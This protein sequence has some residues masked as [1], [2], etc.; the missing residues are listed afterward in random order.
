[1]FVAFALAHNIKMKSRALPTI[2]GLLI[3]FKVLAVDEPQK[4]IATRTTFLDFIQPFSTPPDTNSKSTSLQ[5]SNYTGTAFAGT[6]TDSWNGAWIDYNNDG[7][8]DLFIGSKNGTDDNLL[9][10]NNGNGSFTKITTGTLVNFKARTASSTWADINNDGRIDVFIVNATQDR[11]RLLL[12]NGSGNFSELDNPGIDAQPQY[13][14]GASWLDYDN[15]GYVDLLVTNF[16]ATRFHQLYH[17]NKNNTFT[18]VT[19]TAISLESERSMA[20]I[21]ADYNNDGLVDV[22]IPNGDNRPNSLFKNIGNGQF[23]KITTGAIATDAFNSVG[24][25][26]GDY[27]N[28]GF[29]D[30]FVANAS[31][32]NN[33]L[34]KNNGNGTFTAITNSPIV[35]DSGHT[36]GANWVDI[37][38]DGDLDLYATNDVGVKF[39]Y[40]NDGL[41]NFTRKT[42]ELITEDFGLS[43]GQAWADY[44]RDGFMDVMVFTHSNQPNW[45]FKNNSNSNNKKY[46]SIRLRGTNS[47]RSG[48][49]ATVRVKAGGKW[50][51]RQV[52]AQSGFGSQNSLRVHFG[53][54]SVNKIDSI[55]VKW[56]SGYAQYLRNVS[57]NRFINIVED[58]S[59][60]V[61]GVAF[62]DVNGNCQKESNESVIPNATFKVIGGGPTIVTNNDGIYQV[63]LAQGQHYFSYQNGDSYWYQACNA[64]Y[65][66]GTCNQGPQTVNIP[67]R[68]SNTGF[69]L[70]VSYGSTAWR[71]GFK[72]QGAIQC[73]NT[74]TT[75]AY[76]VTV[77]ATYPQQ[78][79]V[80]SSSKPYISAGNTYTWTIDTLKAGKRIYIQLTDSV[81]L[82]AVVGQRLPIT[83][84]IAAPG[85]DLRLS[86]NTFIDTVE[87]VGAIDPND[88]LVSPRGEGA[89][90]FITKEQPLTYTIRFQNVGTYA[91]DQVILN[92]KIPDYMDINTFQIINA[93]HNYEY[94]L[95]EDGRLIVYF[96]GINLPDSS[97]DL[98]GS[99]GYFKY[100]VKPL[101][102]VSGGEKITNSAEITFDFE[103]PI[104]TNTV[105]NTIKYYSYDKVFSLVV[106]PNPATENA[107]ITFD[108][109]FY[110]FGNSPVIKQLNIYNLSGKIVLSQAGN[111]HS[112]QE[113]NI[114]TLEK[115]YYIIEAIDKDN[116][117]HVGKLTVL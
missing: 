55:E 27:N 77:T 76:N 117:E 8:E 24:A 97:A 2:L 36:H 47:N 67:L 31:N 109:D 115:G 20:P 37:D 74:G 33:N 25:A 82:N 92:N 98:E 66:A 68:A 43:Y 59:A 1:M 21:C 29:M 102:T 39:L 87:I 14:H 111:M 84:Q 83:L 23:E 103:D 56:P 38:N 65:A 91:A 32:Q 44:N 80:V 100:T 51:V 48:I 54:G 58:Q 9:Y 3:T 53:L 95:S 89:D 107:N 104:I 108:K 60:L 7:W 61:S 4:L 57:V 101:Q 85:A 46:I 99:N 6:L 10:R 17:N 70:A 79:R 94:E 42:G 40:M 96:R 78:V 62:N 12:N 64:S 18:L 88:I 63:R 72:N 69:D 45:L 73:Q 112:I 52:V 34:Y 116:N 26:W 75:N 106:F 49:G 110:M 93:S 105:T 86:N 11:S 22:F 30:L 13:F 71:R 114:G 90:A 113:I 16:F 28:D 50:Q 5:F 81:T 35:S 19:N 41:G 15:D